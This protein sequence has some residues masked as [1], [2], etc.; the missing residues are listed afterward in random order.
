MKYCKHCHLPE[1]ECCYHEFSDVPDGCVCNKGE[2]DSLDSI[3]PI[4]EKFV[5][6]NKEGYCSRCEH[7]YGCHKEE[8]KKEV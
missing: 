5:G 4:C 3:P 1:D 2:W 7:D 8:E 6:D